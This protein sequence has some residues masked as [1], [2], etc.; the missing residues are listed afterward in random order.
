VNGRRG[1]SEI[2][3]DLARL[4]SIAPSAEFA[5]RVRQRIGNARA[6][7]QARFGWWIA[8]AAPV[9]LILVVTAI[10]R[11]WRVDEAPREARAAVDTRL[12]SVATPPAA[13]AVGVPA[14]PAAR[15]L[16]QGPGQAFAA[17]GHR[18]PQPEVLVS[19]DQLRAIA[20]LRELIVK[21]ELTDK[22]LPVGGAADG[23]SEIGV[24]P[25]TIAPLTVPPVET[26]GGRRSER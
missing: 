16:A 23:V 15:R 17:A 13:R 8:L 11:P 4:L 2:D 18:Q 6:P 9:A 3:R 12:P 21:G 7:R 20:R 14:R 24:T 25:L 19:R 26:V 1:E 5:A 10:L 22:N